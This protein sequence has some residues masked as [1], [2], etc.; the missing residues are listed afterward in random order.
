[1]SFKKTITSLALLLAFFLP[2]VA[3][4]A[5]LDDSIIAE[6]SCIKG[7]TC[8]LNTFVKLAIN[9]ANFIL[10]IV[11]ALTLLMFIYGGFMWILSGGSS[12]RVKKG[13]DIIIGSIVGLLIVFSSYMIISWV[14]STLGAT[15][16]FEFTG[17]APEETKT[18]N[19]RC[20]LD[21]CKT[22]C[23]P[24]EQKDPVKSCP[25]NTAGKQVCCYKKIDFGVQKCDT[26]YECF[27]ESLCVNGA[28]VTP[29]GACSE[30]DVCCRMR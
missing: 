17:S 7:G 16:G 11:G 23:G 3:L 15:G 26:G 4:G 12:E 19:A 10:G 6:A 14:S 28:P 13:K 27:T 25:D 9:V 20:D 21:H 1:M 29:A 18:I 5:I 24:S 2:L 8:S 30:G 22:T